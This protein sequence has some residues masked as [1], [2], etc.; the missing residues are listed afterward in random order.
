MTYPPLFWQLL[1]AA[2]LK[3]DQSRA[4]LQDLGAGSFDPVSALRT[5]PLLGESGRKKLDRIDLRLFE[6]TLSLPDCRITLPP[7]WNDALN[8]VP[9]PPLALYARGDADTLRTPMIGIVGTRKA[10]PYGQAVA[11]SFASVFARAGLTV[12]SGGA[13]G[14]DAAAHKGALAVGGKTIAVLAHGINHVYP[15]T[16][17]ELFNHIRSSGCLVSPFAV[18]TPSL[19]EHFPRR[20]QLIA[21]L[22]DALLI[23]ECPEKS[24]TLT[25]VTAANNLGREVFVVPGPIDRPG[26]RGSHQ[27]IRDGATLVISPE[28]LLESLGYEAVPEDE[29]P[30][31][32]LSD[33]QSLIL[34]HLGTDPLSPEAIG[35]KTDLDPTIILSELT[36]MEMEGLVFKSSTGYSLSINPRP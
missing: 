19:S 25:T 13:L 34:T 11:Y 5:H 28:Q 29:A 33:I 36:I 9:L 32:D 23:V 22:C 8:Q 7:D 27:L 4:I 3:P 6:K 26:F 12:V 35:L 20:N 18:G 21:S 1:L 15:S 24:G 17:K 16:H 14:I 10:T 31:L 30:D 2:D